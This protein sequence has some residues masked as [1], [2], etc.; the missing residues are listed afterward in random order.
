[1]PAE[2]ARRWTLSGATRLDPQS[3]VSHVE[4]LVF[5]GPEIPVGTREPVLSEA[6][7]Q[8]EIAELR[9]TV[10]PTRDSRLVL[11]DLVERLDLDGESST[12]KGSDGA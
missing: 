4:V 7:C 12:S 5:A 8:R 3:G 6:D 10:S 11:D 9:R 1:M 2:Q